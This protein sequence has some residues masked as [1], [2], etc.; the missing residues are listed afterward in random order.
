M[1]K[2]QDDSIQRYIDW[3]KSTGKKPQEAKNIEEYKKYR[4]TLEVGYVGN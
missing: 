3:C 2:M 1:I 4:K